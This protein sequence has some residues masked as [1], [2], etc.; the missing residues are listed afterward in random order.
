MDPAEK[1]RIRVEAAFERREGRKL[2][3]RER[4][5]VTAAAHGATDD[6]H[7]EC[8]VP[9][10][11]A[12]MK[13]DSSLVGTVGS[14]ALVPAA[15]Y[16]GTLDAVRFLLEQGVDELYDCQTGMD[17]GHEYHPIFRA[18]AKGNLQSLR[19]LFDA[20]VSNANVVN[21]KPRGIPG[22]ATL[23]YG[24]IH[25]P[26]EV[27]GFVLEYGGDLEAEVTGNGER[28]RTVLQDAVA[29]PFDGAFAPWPNP[30]LWSERMQFAE[31]LLERG[32]YHDIYSACGRDD[33]ARVRE[34]VENDAASIMAR[35]E[36]GMTPLHWAVRGDAPRCATW[37]L[38]NGAE[39]DAVT[40][41]DR[42]PLHLAAEWG[43]TEMIWLLAAR[44]ADLNQPDSK[45]RTP[46]HR[47]TYT[48]EVEAAEILIVLGADTSIETPAGK[49]AI[50]LARF[51]CK[52][53]KEAS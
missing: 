18:F 43:L 47:S 11:K 2:T 52:F 9:R 40:E 37:L 53:L 46:L 38:A 27:A 45:G 14:L 32:A 5:F 51:G 22:H 12:L 8:D 48:G 29:P 36:A 24:C 39:V 26:R 25:K 1:V 23:L 10:M 13:E 41:T 50:Q 28:G 20:G 4:E 31:F 49:T 34:L 7:A 16:H 30:K 3:R 15:V 35:H 19:T 42:T 33:L 21:A 6:S 17:R 44:G